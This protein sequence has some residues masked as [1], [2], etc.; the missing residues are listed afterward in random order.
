MSQMAY[1]KKRI[2]F[3]I[4]AFILIGLLHLSSASENDLSELKRL[5]F[6]FDD[7]KITSQDLAFFL[8]THNFNAKPMREYVELDL[9][10]VIYK[11]IPNRDKPGLC[12]ILPSDSPL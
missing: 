5:T 2:V 1:A 3:A 10:G 12:D 6:S 8:L 9:N 11:L 4:L 7:P